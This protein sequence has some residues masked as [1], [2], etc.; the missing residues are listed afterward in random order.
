MVKDSRFPP[1]GGEAPRRF[2]LVAAFLIAAAV[3]SASL[4][5]LE[6]RVVECDVVGDRALRLVAVP[7]SG[8]ETVE[9]E[10]EKRFVRLELGDGEGPWDL[11]VATPGLWSEERRVTQSVAQPVELHVWRQ[12]R[13]AGLVVAPRPEPAPEEVIWRLR[14]VRRPGPSE[15]E[16]CRVEELLVSCPVG[17]RGAF[18]CALPSGRWNLRAKAEGWAAR[19][20]WAVELAA[21][22]EVDLG[23]L[24][25]RRGATLL[26]EV[27]TV[28]GPALPE[29]TRVQLRPLGVLDPDPDV[30]HERQSLDLT[31]R[32]NEQGYFLFEDVP[33]GLYEVEAHQPGYSVARM[34][35]VEVRADLETTLLQPLVLAAP[36]HLT[37]AVEPPHAPNEGSWRVRLD[38]AGATTSAAGEAVEGATDEEGRWTSPALD[39]GQYLVRVLDDGGNVLAMEGPMSFA[40]VQDPF[41]QVSLDLVEIA[42]EVRLG[43]EPLAA[44]LWFGGQTGAR[45]VHVTSDREGRFEAV[46]PHDGTWRV[47]V[48][49]ATE[50]VAARALSVEVQKGDDDLLIELPATELLGS[51]VDATGA[52]VPE[53]RVQV[54]R[55]GEGGP[56]LTATDDE[57]HFLVRGLPPGTF[58]L[59]AV[60]GERSSAMH[61]TTVVED[62]TPPPVRLVIEDRVV[63]AGRVVAEGGSVAGAAVVALPVLANGTMGS[64]SDTVSGVDGGFSL[65]LPAA[66]SEALL[67]VMPLGFGLTLER[68]AVGGERSG[69]VEV[70]AAPAEGALRLAAPRQG[71]G[72]VA[73]LL[74][75]GEPLDVHLLRQWA[76]FQGAEPADT[77]E[78]LI[79]ALPSGPY[80]YCTMAI[81]EA[82]LVIAGRA[83]PTRCTTGLL[84]PGGELALAPP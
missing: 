2:A 52:P 78:V 79:P 10:A 59:E 33:P 32:L 73:L 63:L 49:A 16:R 72:E 83:R 23:R 39:V 55:V 35:P 17:E 19:H 50:H 21:G 56:F 12:A 6:V 65:R 41:V 29:A 25:L 40:G 74:V 13:L 71:D 9:V 76:A 28:D 82:L 31:A 70:R 62:V 66:T 1:P 37:V 24:P 20:L 58:W 68:I 51:V 3:P 30:V 18:D 5:G 81:D 75:A 15:P 38:P 54:V 80:A 4:F 84:S 46:L 14:P 7:P 48:F 61:T 43:D 8:Q 45:K 36:I 64:P 77:G 34:A 47:D 42:G 44:E 53:A 60:S 69:P 67:V 26:G 27:T 22:T 57:G 11:R